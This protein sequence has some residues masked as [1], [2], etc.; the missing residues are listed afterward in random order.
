MKIPTLVHPNSKTIFKYQDCYKIMAMYSL[1]TA[2]GWILKG[3]QFA[4]GG[5]LT[6][7]QKY[8]EQQ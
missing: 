7:L 2:N 3:V 6:K 5:S 8:Q 1:G 4:Q